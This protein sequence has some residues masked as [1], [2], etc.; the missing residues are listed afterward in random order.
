MEI[1]KD[2]SRRPDTKRWPATRVIGMVFASIG[3]L[4]ALALLV[5]GITVLATYAFGRDDQGYFTTDRQ[6]LQSGAYAITTE[7]IDLGVDEVGWAPDKLLGNL[8]VQVDGEKPLFVGVGSDDDVERYLREV[9]HDELIGFDG[10]DPELDKH[11]GR[12][13]QKPPAD[14]DFWVAESEGSG[15]QALTWEAEFGRW[16]LVVMNADAARG[17]DVEADVGVKLDWAIW[18][19]LGMFVIGLLMTVGAVIVI[20][21]IGRRAS[22]ESA[23]I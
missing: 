21:L 3:G 22:R 5:G 20:L 23:A 11:G 6:Q 16:T 14:Q 9:A 2:Q 8:R 17:I 10:D 19:G 15:E 1:S 7:D 18:A 13:P 12:A 4:I